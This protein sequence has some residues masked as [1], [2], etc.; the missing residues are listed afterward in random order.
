MLHR[1][2]LPRT[3]L[4][5]IEI[6]SYLLVTGIF[7]LAFAGGSSGMDDILGEW[8]GRVEPKGIPVTLE[9]KADKSAVLSYNDSFRA[10]DA[11]ATSCRM[12]GGSTYTCYF[13]YEHGGS[14]QGWCE[15]LLDTEMG[16]TIQKD[17]LEVH[18]KTIAVDETY[19][20]TRE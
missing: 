14:V 17:E 12:R 18:I 1:T 3:K 19:I 13:T 8:E 5:V 10:C 2:T 4:T 20:L 16:L 11:T 7:C 15:S 6:L 9:L